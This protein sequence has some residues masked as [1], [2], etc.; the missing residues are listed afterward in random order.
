VEFSD[1]YT[2]Q[3]KQ[4][5]AKGNLLSPGGRGGRDTHPFEENVGQILPGSD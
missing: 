1:F 4:A 5:A 2:E 3:Q